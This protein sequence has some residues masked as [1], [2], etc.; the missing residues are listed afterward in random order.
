[1]KGTKRVDMGGAGG[2][3][4]GVRWCIGPCPIPRVQ[5]VAQSHP[6]GFGIRG[7]ALPRYIMA[8]TTS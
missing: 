1:M 5:C 8:A 6:S 7:G 2:W 4:K 3:R